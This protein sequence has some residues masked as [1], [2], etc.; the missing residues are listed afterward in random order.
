MHLS[1]LAHLLQGGMDDTG[2]ANYCT[3]LNRLHTFE[4]YGLYQG[5][6]YT[7]I[8]RQRVRWVCRALL[9]PRRSLYTA[10]AIG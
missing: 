7:A 4:R 8:V 10:Q 2:A 1:H 3:R 9:T 5:D 6:R